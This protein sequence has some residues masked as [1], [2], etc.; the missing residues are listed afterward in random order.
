MWLA[1]VPDRIV[2]LVKTRLV[3]LSAPGRPRWHTVTASAHLA[4]HR[5]PAGQDGGT[6]LARN[7]PTCSEITL[8]V[9]SSF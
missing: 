8:L 1:P 5:R 9:G 7:E 6:E 4:T 3:L 2:R